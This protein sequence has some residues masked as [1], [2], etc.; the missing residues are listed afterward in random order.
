MY[1]NQMIAMTLCGLWHGASL[2]FVLWGTLHGLGV[3]V[4]KFFSQTVLHHDRHYHPSGLRRVVAVVLTF[5][6]VTF[7]WIFFRT[8]DFQSATLL[9]NQLL[10]KFDVSLIP[11]IFAAYKYVFALIGLALLTHWIPDTWQ[12]KIVLGLQKGGVVVC[13]VAL[14]FVVFLAMQVKSSDIQPFIYLQL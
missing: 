11:A 3:C 5:H 9:I 2:N 8:P 4:H 10:T 14:T 6:L 7:L 1:V 12:D 13:A